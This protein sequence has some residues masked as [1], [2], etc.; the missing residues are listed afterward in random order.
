MAS[1]TFVTAGS[2]SYSTS[3]R[4]SASSAA[5]GVAAATAAIPWPANS[6][7]SRASAV[8]RMWQSCTSAAASASSAGRSAAVTTARTSGS[9]S[10]PLTSTDSSRAWACGLRSTLACSIPG[11]R[12][13]AP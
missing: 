6:T 10:A 3:I 5:W 9:P 7:L 1:S 13:S 2:T 12:T 4:D 8:S 11:S